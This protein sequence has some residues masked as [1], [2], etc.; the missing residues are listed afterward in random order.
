MTTLDCRGQPC[1]RP[2]IE[3]A[4]AIGRVAL[5]Q[6]LEVLAD[7]PGARAD[8]PAWCRL[9]GQEYL[10]EQPDGCYRVRRTR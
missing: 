10:G 7:D 6:V 5:G 4:R 9:R 3:L 2:V 8:I 1:P